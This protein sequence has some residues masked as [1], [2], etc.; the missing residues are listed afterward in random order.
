MTLK[1]NILRYADTIGTRT[2]FTLDELMLSLQIDARRNTV[3][4]AL[5]ELVK[6]GTV[7]RISKGLFFFPL[8]IPSLIAGTTENRAITTEKLWLGEKN[9]VIGYISGPA[10]AA[11]LGLQTLL[12]A[13]IDVYTNQWRKNKALADT[14]GYKL[15]KPKLK[16]SKENY[17][18]LRLLDALSDRAAFDSNNQIEII[19]REVDD[20]ELDVHKLLQ[21][22]QQHYSKEV[23]LMLLRGIYA[24]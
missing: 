7:R 17:K 19:K 6:S 23:I 3:S 2:P 13:V 8:E 24:S 12:P 22:A 16:I 18:E 4:K 10:Y 15:H 20:K 14:Y 5:F 1:E 9:D 11:E 21:L